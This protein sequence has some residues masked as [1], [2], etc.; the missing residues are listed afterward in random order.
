MH[1]IR[2]RAAWKPHSTIPQAFTRRFNKPTSIE[3]EAV[4]LAV[5]TLPVEAQINGEPLEWDPASYRV[6]ITAQ[7]ELSNELMFQ[8][9][10]EALLKTVRLEIEA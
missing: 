2:L 5:D 6:D 10:D 1:T 4:W 8:V 9:D 3:R 7:L